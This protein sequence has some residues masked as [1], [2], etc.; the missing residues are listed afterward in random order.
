MSIQRRS[1]LAA[2]LF[3]AAGVVTAGK[4]GAAAV[5]ESEFFP[6]VETVQGRVRGVSV[7]GVNIFKGLH[8][9]G[10]TSGRRRFTP[11]P[12]PTKWAGVRDAFEFG[13]NCPQQPIDFGLP[14]GGLGEDC[15]VLNVFTP[16]TDRN[17]KR[18]VLVH[19]HGGAL[20]VGSSNS[21]QGEEMARFGD[22]VVV[23]VNHRIGVFGQLDLAHRVPGLANSGQVG[24]MDLVAA[25]KWVH[26][27][28]EGFGGDPSRVLIFG[29]SGGG[30]KTLIMMAMPS[31]KGLFQRAGVQSSGLLRLP[32]AEQAQARADLML[33]TLGIAKNDAASI[34]NIS[35][36]RLMAGRVAMGPEGVFDPSIDGHVIPS[37]PFDPDAP[38]VS[39]DVPM[40]I[41]TS[42][43]ERAYLM[44]NYDLTEAGLRTFIA[45]RVGEA[46]ADQVLAMYRDDDPYA[47]PFVIQAR[48]DTDEGFRLPMLRMADLKSAQAAK[49]GAPVWSYLWRQAG[50]AYGG[51]QGAP[52]GSDDGPGMH[53]PRTGID[54]DPENLRLADQ[55]ASVW[56]NFAATGNPNNPRIPH[57]P[58]YTVPE[59][60]TLVI[61]RHPFV[62]NDPRGRFR[63]FWAKE[64]SIYEP[65][66]PYRLGVVGNE[67]FLKK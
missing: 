24:M 5:S 62:E 60:A 66:R 37:Q 15:L 56:V 47:T 26:D 54:T 22:C 21:D 58:A 63:E 6:I 7:R 11:P 52:H 44:S 31:A 10:D 50:R 55:M 25:L 9:G 28:I 13:Q 46:R 67:D 43:D 29:L 27:N 59:R 32:T 16:T 12:S 51:R 17:G 61:D 8:Y 4:V 23:T 30:E 34:Q 35:I 2:G 65:G 3:L 53:E 40:I 39:A 45:K 19:F 49:G 41:S 18:P 1:M 20:V 42:L 38:N 33:T 36:E 48:F 57:W 14:P 64:P